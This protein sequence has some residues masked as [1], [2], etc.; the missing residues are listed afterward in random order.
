MSM[1]SWTEEGYGFSL[2]NGKNLENIKSFIIDNCKFRL[3]FSY[4]FNNEE[5]E[6]IKAAEDL[7][8]IREITS[9]P[10]SWIVAAI[11]ND[12]EFTWSAVMGYDS[13]GD[14]DQDEMIGI[15][16]IYPWNPNQT[17]TKEKAT[18]V[19]EKYA[20]ILG[21]EEEPDYFEAEYYG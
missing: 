3:D 21:I 6:A 11:I 14:T 13:C 2:Y 17:I 5:I 16:P 10:T 9:D 18:E 19:L 20:K 15:A 7:E 4:S 8:D 1:K 12:K